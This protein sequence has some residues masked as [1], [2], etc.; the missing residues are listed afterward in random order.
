MSDLTAAFAIWLPAGTLLPLAISK[1]T[2]ASWRSAVIEAC[3]FACLG[4]F[5]FPTMLALLTARFVHVRSA[6]PL[7]IGSYVLTTLCLLYYRRR[8]HPPSRWRR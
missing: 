6:N 2:G 1:L 3:I 5:I 8:S 7:F 4:L